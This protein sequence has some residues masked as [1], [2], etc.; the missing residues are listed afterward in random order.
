[1]QNKSSGSESTLLTHQNISKS[2]RQPDFEL[3][4]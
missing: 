2:S 1:M 4:D 3:A